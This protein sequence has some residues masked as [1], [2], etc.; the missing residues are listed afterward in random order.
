MKIPPS[1]LVHPA[2]FDR[3]FGFRDFL[4]NLFFFCEKNAHYPA[5]AAVTI[6]TANTARDLLPPA[7]YPGA[8]LPC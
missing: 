1:S 3:W 5:W 7:D 6:Q 4:F 2:I 8:P